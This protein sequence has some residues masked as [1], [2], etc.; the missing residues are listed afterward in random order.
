MMQLANFLPGQGKNHELYPYAL[1]MYRFLRALKAEIK[2]MPANP[3]PLPWP[4]Q[5]LPSEL[6]RRWNSGLFPTIPDRPKRR[7]PLNTYVPATVDMN[8][9]RTEVYRP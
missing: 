1:W 6:A 8:T 2:Q 3:P 5:P 9:V 4:V 7:P